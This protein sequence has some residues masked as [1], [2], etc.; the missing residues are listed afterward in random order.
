MEVLVSIPIAAKT[1]QNPRNKQT[2]NNENNKTIAHTTQSHE[3]A[4]LRL[5]NPSSEHLLLRCGLHLVP[6]NFF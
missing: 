6:L 3:M 4:S 2:N 5:P 1:K